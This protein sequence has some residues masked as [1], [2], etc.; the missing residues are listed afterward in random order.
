VVKWRLL[1]EDVGPAVL[2]RAGG[3][4]GVVPRNPLNPQ[5]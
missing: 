1:E 5:T 2:G 4:I 3:V